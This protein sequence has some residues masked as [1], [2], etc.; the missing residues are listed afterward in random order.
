[1]FLIVNIFYYIFNTA[2]ENHAKVVQL[3]RGYSVAFSYSVDCCAADT[4]FV[5]KSV[6]AFT[7]L[8]ESP[9][10]RIVYNHF[11]TTFNGMI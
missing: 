2:T 6:G 9:P 1:M 10:E 7:P 4:V 3:L 8:F 5:Y 11:I